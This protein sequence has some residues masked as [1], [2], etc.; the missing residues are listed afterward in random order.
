MEMAASL[1][2]PVTPESTAPCKVA[3]FCED[4]SAQVKAMDLSQRLPTRFSEDDYVPNQHSH[5]H[6]GLNE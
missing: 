5:D 2:L 1:P 4:A 3:I 6:W